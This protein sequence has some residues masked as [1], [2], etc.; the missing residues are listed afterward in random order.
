MRP[1][2]LSTLLLSAVVNA[3]STPDPVQTLIDAFIAHHNLLQGRK[4][5]Q[6]CQ[7]QPLRTQPSDHVIAMRRFAQQFEIESYDRHINR[8][9][10]NTQS[11]I[12]TAKLSK[13]E[14]ALCNRP[15]PG[16]QTKDGKTVT[17]V[18]NELVSQY[19]ICEL[20]NVRIALPFPHPESRKAF[21]S[22]KF[23]MTAGYQTYPNFGM[24]ID[25]TPEYAG[26]VTRLGFS[27]FCCLADGD[28]TTALFHRIPLVLRNNILRICGKYIQL[29]GKPTT[30]F[31]T[32]DT[33]I[34]KIVV[35]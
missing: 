25:F 18:R 1:L 24:R 32:N 21:G 2:I 7:P 22:S 19:W 27:G 30:I 3:A 29:N 9:V 23:V 5:R 34:D 12:G 33:T 16:L 15:F 11:N 6:P 31:L 26:G 35:N 17:E 14:F 20:G 8:P 28:T 4:P 10:E 13:T